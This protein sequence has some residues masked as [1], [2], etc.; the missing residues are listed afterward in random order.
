MSDLEGSW[1]A[2]LPVSPKTACDAVLHV[3]DYPSWWSRSVTTGL[4]RGTNGKAITGSLIGFRL[5]ALSLEFTVRRIDAGRRIE[6]DC[7]GGGR[8]GSAEWTFV[9]ESRGV[10]ATHSVSLAP[11]GLFSKLLGGASD[12]VA[13]YGKAVTSALERL[14]ANLAG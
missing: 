9:P 11:A 4:V 1:S 8:K 7:V 12:V 6:F 14:A 2:Y 3:V 10:R 13:V 5:D